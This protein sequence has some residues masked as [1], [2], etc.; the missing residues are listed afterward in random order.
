MRTLPL[1]LPFTEFAKASG[2]TGV[3]EKEFE[4]GR[5]APQQQDLMH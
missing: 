1:Q 3:C 5:E 2:M 4:E